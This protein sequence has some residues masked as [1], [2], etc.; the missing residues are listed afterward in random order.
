MFYLVIVI[1]IFLANF[2]LGFNIS[3]LNI[4]KILLVLLFIINFKLKDS[5]QSNNYFN[6]LNKNKEQKLNNNNN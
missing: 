6:Y 2:L 4:V 1:L 5:F 3:L